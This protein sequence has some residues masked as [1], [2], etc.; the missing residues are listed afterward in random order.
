MVG[1][2]NAKAEQMIGYEAG[3]RTQIK[4]NLYLDFAAF[5][6]NYSGL[7]AYGPP[8]IAESADPPPLHLFFV[9][10]Y[11]NIVQGNTVGG[12]IAPDWKITHWWQLRG[13]YAYLDMA[14]H[15]KTGFTDVGN[16]LSSYNGSSPRHVVSAQSFFNLPKHFEFDVTYRYSSALPAYSASAYS[17]ADA[18]LGWHL[19]ENIEFSVVGQNLLQP[20][21]PEF[22]GNPGPLVGIKR[23]AF[24]KLTWRK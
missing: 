6:N 23:S 10:P 19:G 21:H 20:Y 7:Q 8:G 18:R 22:G 1:N 3:Y 15:D 2:P 11:A 14:L 5:Y 16:L 9:L 4:A 13:S 24:A 12:E 17:T